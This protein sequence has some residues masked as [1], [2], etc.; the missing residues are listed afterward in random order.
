MKLLLC[1]LKQ[2]FA[3]TVS[4]HQFF[5]ER[6]MQNTFYKTQIDAKQGL[7]TSA[8]GIQLA[9][10]GRKKEKKDSAGKT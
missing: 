9:V 4:G 5:S 8:P 2:C 1:H 3:P 10:K 7:F 6:L